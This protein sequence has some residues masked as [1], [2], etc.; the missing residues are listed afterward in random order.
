MNINRA[1]DTSASRP[2]IKTT[3]A[4][5]Q[6][7]TA[8]SVNPVRGTEAAGLQR[9]T[10]CCWAFE[11]ASAIQARDKP[12]LDIDVEGDGDWR[13]GG[14]TYE[15]GNMVVADTELPPLNKEY[16]L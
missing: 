6:A 11:T 5:I 14:E 1:L 2:S 16:K 9:A 7:I 13:G 15:S 4:P 10:L 3:P 8:Y 12:N